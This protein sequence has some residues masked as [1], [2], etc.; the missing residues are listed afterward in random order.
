MTA[1]V[2]APA[3]ARTRDRL[4]R[5]GDLAHRA[6]ACRQPVDLLRHP[7]AHPRRRVGGHDGHRAHHPGRRGAT[8]RDAEGFRYSWA[9]LSPQW[10]LV[11]VG[12]Q[13]I[14]VHVL[15]RA[16]IRRHAP[17]LLARHERHVRHRLGPHR[18]RHRD[19][20]AGR[21]SRPTAG[22]SAPTCSTPSGT[23]S[24]AGSSTLHDVRAAT[25]RALHRGERDDGLH[26]LAHP[27]HDDPPLRRGPVSSRSSRRSR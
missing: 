21:A 22:A 18:D 16:R 9:V 11:V 10:Y 27:G 4:P 23:A 24:R 14:G 26:A 25:G 20:R 15:V 17:R 3:V 13:A 7:V 12:V 5:A 2:A 6:P 1:V 19:A 8:R